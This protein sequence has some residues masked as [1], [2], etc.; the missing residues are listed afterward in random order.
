METFGQRLRRIRTKQGM[1]QVALGE[2]AGMDRSHIIKI[3]TGRIM[4]PATETVQRLAAALGVAPSDLMPVADMLPP[5]PDVESDELVQ[6]FDRLP[7]DDRTR[8]VAIARTLY[9]M[10]REH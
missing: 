2:R 8:L 5:A 9:Q 1:S 3:E 10:S 7:H 6:L 4:E